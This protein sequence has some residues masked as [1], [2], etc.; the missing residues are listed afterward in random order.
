MLFNKK[1][2]TKNIYGEYLKSN[3]NDK[4]MSKLF[5]NSNHASIAAQRCATN[6]SIQSQGEKK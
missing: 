2:S 5:E 6:R 3:K 4:N 1:K